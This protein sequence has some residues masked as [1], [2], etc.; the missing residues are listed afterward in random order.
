VSADRPHETLT[1]LARAAWQP[2]AKRELTR[3]DG[4]EIIANVTG[5]FRVLREWAARDRS[6]RG[7]S[8]R[9]AEERRT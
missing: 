5:F 2:R 4:R 7:D 6:A 9:Q 3:E 8:G 1:E